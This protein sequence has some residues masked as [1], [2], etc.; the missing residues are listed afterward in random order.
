MTKHVGNEIT[1]VRLAVERP[2]KLGSGSGRVRL[3]F[4]SF[5]PVDIPQA[6][7]ELT[8]ALR[9]SATAWRDPTMTEYEPHFFRY[10]SVKS[11]NLPFRSVSTKCPLCT[12]KHLGFGETKIN[13][14]GGFPAKRRRQAK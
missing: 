4:L 13:K 14:T 10:E 2:E 8:Q 7:T 3:R 6:I 1:K 5:T 12:C 9:C 11:V